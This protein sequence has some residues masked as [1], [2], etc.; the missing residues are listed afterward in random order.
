MTRRWVGR[1]VQLVSDGPSTTHAA[2]DGATV[3]RWIRESADVF[4]SQR[5]YL[6]QLDAAIGDADHGINMDRGF[7]AAVVDLD[8][9]D[10]S[11]PGEL[12][13]RVGST[14]VY[15][16]GGA[17]GPL[18]GG[19]FRQAGSALGDHRDLRCRGP[20][21]GA[22]RGPGRDPRP[23]C[24]GRGRQD[25]RRRV[26]AGP[27]GVRTRPARGTRRRAGVPPRGGGREGRVAR[28]RCRCRRGRAVPPTW[29]L[30]ASDIR[31]QAPP[32]RRCSSPR[33][34]KVGRVTSRDRRG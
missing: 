32:R 8:A 18:F 23:G 6:T 20:A 16:V 19:C 1:M 33:W 7:S 27:A 11:A 3:R 28:A 13:T 25:D 31:I 21:E 2:L 22:P 30:G 4:S 34:R 14:L 26:R 17:A 9:V 5:D 24:R 29:G 15:R 10:G 12:L